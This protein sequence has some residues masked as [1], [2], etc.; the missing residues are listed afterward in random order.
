M[1]SPR[2]RHRHQGRNLQALRIS[3][4]HRPFVSK[5]SSHLSSLLDTVKLRNHRG[6]SVTPHRE[7]RSNPA[8][9]PLNSDTTVRVKTPSAGDSCIPSLLAFEP[10]QSLL[11]RCAVSK[12]K[13][14]QTMGIRR[15]KPSCSSVFSFISLNEHKQRTE[16]YRHFHTYQ[17]PFIR[18][19]HLTPASP[20]IGIHTHTSASTHTHRHRY[21]SASTNRTKL[22]I[23]KS[24]ITSNT[25]P[26]TVRHNARGRPLAKWSSTY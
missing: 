12:L 22:Q 1:L 3:A 13:P 18:A 6:Q 15:T 10:L 24:Y 17:Q 2:F 11:Q 21:T 5:S 19:S 23:S 26:L 20:H 7:S 16:I 9:F 25:K 8:F 4:D 14:R